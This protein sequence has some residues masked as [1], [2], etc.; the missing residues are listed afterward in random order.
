MPS[1]TVKLTI[2]EVRE[3]I[4]DWLDSNGFVTTT[5]LLLEYE[6][7]DKYNMNAHAIKGVYIKEKEKETK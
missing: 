3:A 7:V 5:S 6:V 2:D 1:I 4:G